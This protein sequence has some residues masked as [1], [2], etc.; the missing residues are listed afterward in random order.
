MTIDTDRRTA[1]PLALALSTVILSSCASTNLTREAEQA[2][3]AGRHDQAV[4]L[5]TQALTE[6]PGDPRLAE[7]LARA[8]IRAS[9]AHALEAARRMTAGDLAGARNE[10]EVALTMNPTDARIARDI[11]ELDA[12]IAEQG[13]AAER[14]SIASLKRKVN[15]A[16]LGSLSVSPGAVAPAEFV[17]RDAS[18]RDVLL[19]LGTLAGVNVIFDE[20][21]RDRTISIDLEDATFEEAF[22]SLCTTTRNFYRVESDRLITIVPDTEAKRREYEQ[23]VTRTFYLSSADLKE[24]IDL[25]RIVLGARRVA[26]LTA[27][28]ALTLVDTPERIQAAETIIDSLDKSRSEVIVEMEVL[29]VNRIRM[30]EYGIQLRSAGTDGISASIFPG[31]TTADQSPYAPENLFVT[32]LPGAVLSLVRADGDTRILANPQLRAV[33]GESAQAEFGERV[34]VPITTFTPIATGGVPQQPVTTF[35]YENI[36]VNILVTPR[37][38]HD[39]EI[40]LALEI[41]LSTITG[42]GFGG[43]PTFGNRSVNTVLRLADGETSLLAGLISNEERASLKGTPGLANVPIL[44]RI[45]A[46]NSKEVRETDI[47]L[48]MT[49]RIIRRADLSIEDLL[50]HAIDGVGGSNILYEP[51]QPLPRREPEEVPEGE[52][53]RPIPN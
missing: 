46:A 50:P 36:G 37:V 26:P 17:F 7:N 4:A 25:L 47:V 52:R 16:P 42:T 6:K 43:L 5:Y 2:E 21:F 34:P 9:A 30:E 18:L 48:M 20:G 12:R 1:L 10:L 11:E 15:E 31:D 24:T 29:E 39:N 41:R 40:S 19:S 13:E 23:Q 32:G 28:N 14:A 51:P 38:H 49:P 3:R 44:G 22:R 53:K 27:A 8:R 45:F 35:Q 33:D